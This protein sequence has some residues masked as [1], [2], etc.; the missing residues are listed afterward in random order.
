MELENKGSQALGSDPY[1]PVFGTIDDQIKPLLETRGKLLDKISAPPEASRD[2]TIGNMLAT[3][4]NFSIGMAAGGGKHGLALG[5]QGAGD[6][7]VAWAKDQA[8]RAKQAQTIGMEQ[9]KGID[10]QVGMLQ[11]ER[12]NTAQASAQ[13][14]SRRQMA[15]DEGRIPSTDPTSPYGIN[16]GLKAQ[17]EKTK[18]HETQR[19]EQEVK[20]Y[21][22]N[23]D[24]AENVKAALAGNAV[25]AGKITA[26]PNA[27]KGLISRVAAMGNMGARAGGLN[28]RTQMQQADMG[29]FFKGSI[30]QPRVNEDGDAT[31]ALHKMKDPKAK[32]TIST[33][34]QTLP[35]AV[36]NIDMNIA[37]LKKVGS[38]F[39]ENPDDP[40]AQQELGK[41][42]QQSKEGFL[43]LANM[44]ATLAPAF[45]KGGM[46]DMQRRQFLEKISPPSQIDTL[47]S[48]DSDTLKQSAVNSLPLIIGRLEE[49]KREFLSK[50][51]DT[52]NAFGLDMDLNRAYKNANPYALG[53]PSEGGAPI[54]QKASS[55]ASAW[56]IK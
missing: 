51:W 15:Y 54:T 16:E 17:G 53:S 5:L 9:I 55:L 42:I 48:A 25:A 24:N 10:S 46:T 36:R 29:D 19:E 3:L 23:P 1:A 37:A 44:E 6:T 22:T 56:G 45:T 18:A 40:A 52:G 32:E 34:N 50:A 7:G 38:V 14:A 39:A 35:F 43:Q 41:T 49:A 20:D 8:D 27:P 12:I 21:L 4:A 30:F 47:A 26:D 28:L 2:S 33:I 13:D 31:A 11:H